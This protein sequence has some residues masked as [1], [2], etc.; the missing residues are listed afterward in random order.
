[1]SRGVHPA[2]HTKS[3]VKLECKYCEKDICA[4]GMRALLLADTNVELYSTDFPPENAIQL[5]GAD[6]STE[7]C[8]CRIK[9]VACLGC[10][11]VVGYHVTLPC[12]S[13]IT[14]CNN[15]HFW[16]FH[17]SAV[18]P[19]ERLDQTGIQIMLW[20]SLSNSKEEN[21]FPDDSMWMEECIR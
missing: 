12:K 5:I 10:G 18:I 2:F 14:S 20:G 17:A 21:E 4:R 7:N 9:D 16:M 15:G 11:N 1:M 6:Y 13:C 3:V 8:E 19:A